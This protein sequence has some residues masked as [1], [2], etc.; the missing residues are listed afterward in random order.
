MFFTANARA[1]KGLIIGI[2]LAYFA[3]FS[4]CMTIITYAVLILKKSG[5]SLNPYTSSIALAANLII[6]N[7]CTA[8]CADKLGRK[9][10]MIISLLGSAA[11]LITLSGYMYMCQIGFELQ[12][13]S[14]I[15]VA[16]L[17]WLVFISSAGIIPLSHVCR[18]ENLP[19]KV[20]TCQITMLLFATHFTQTTFK[21]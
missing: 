3:Q 15:P 2:F 16:S 6:G 10:F 7:L 12:A 19:T 21:L 8:Q 17:A 13:Y 9:T 4:G 20:S 11:G 1:V 5:T 14:W 18:V